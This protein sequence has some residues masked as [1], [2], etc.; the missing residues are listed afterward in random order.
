MPVRCQ[1]CNHHFLLD[2]T[3]VVNGIGCPECGGKTI[4]R[5][6]PSPTHSDGDLRDMVDPATQLD[7]G[8]NPLQEGV[9]AGID[10]GWQPSYRRDESF[11]HVIGAQRVEHPELP[12]AHCGRRGA[13]G[14]YPIRGDAQ[15]RRCGAVFPI[16]ADMGL[17]Q[18]MDVE[19]YRDYP[20][21]FDL[22]KHEIPAN[23]GPTH[24]G[25]TASVLPPPSGIEPQHHFVATPGWAGLHNGNMYWLGYLDASVNGTPV[26]GNMQDLY[27]K[28]GF[29]KHPDFRK[30]VTISVHHPEYEAA[31][32]EIV[33]SGD[34]RSY[35]E[36]MKQFAPTLLETGRK[37]AA[38]QIPAPPG[39]NPPQPQAP[40]V[41]SNHYSRSL[42]MEPYM[43]WWHEAVTRYPAGG[44]EPQELSTEQWANDRRQRHQD[45]QL[46]QGGHRLQ[47]QPGAQGRGIMIGSSLH[48]WPVE[49]TMDDAQGG[50]M[51]G[52]YVKQLGVNPANI[53]L[54][55]GFEIEPDGRVV[56]S[57]VNPAIHTIDP[58]LTPSTEEWGQ[59]FGKTGFAFLAPL[60]AQG[61]RML[62]ARALPSLMG[63]AVRGMG[64]HAQSVPPQPEEYQG[65]RPLNMVAKYANLSFRDMMAM[66]TTAEQRAR[67]L[68]MTGG[69]RQEAFNAGKEYHEIADAIQAQ[70]G[71]N[72]RPDYGIDDDASGIHAHV[73]EALGVG[74]PVETPGSVPDMVEDHDP[75]AV[76]QQEF[77]DGDMSPAFNNP[78]KDDADAGMARSVGEDGVN[79][80][81]E[82][83]HD[84]D[85]VSQAELLLPLIMEYVNS[86]KSA[87]ENPQLKAL[88][89]VLDVEIP[90]YIQHASE[91]D[92]AFHEFM[93]AIKKPQGVEAKVGA[94][95]YQNT[96]MNPNQMAMG[97]QQMQ[98]PQMPMPGTHQNPIGPGGMSVQGKCMN[99][100]GVTNADG[101][102]PQCG[103]SPGANQ[104]GNLEQPGGTAMTQRTPLGIMPSPYA[105]TGANHQ[106]PITPQQKEVFSEYLIQQ[107]RNDEVAAMMV[108]PAIY[109]DEWAQFLNRGTQPPEVDP[110]EQP[111]PQPQMDPS[112]MGQMPVPG[113]SIPPGGGPVASVKTANVSQRAMEIS[114][115]LE[116]QGI[117][118]EQAWQMARRQAQEEFG[119]STDPYNGFQQTMKDFIDRSSRTADSDRRCPECTSA[120]T[121]VMNE[122]G[123]MRCHRCG[124][125]WKA[126]LVK[127]RVSRTW[128]IVAFQDNMTPPS[129]TA[130]TSTPNPIT[131][132]A[133]DLTAPGDREQQADSTLTWQDTGGQPLQV[134]QVYEMHSAV[135]PIPDM[136]KV[137]AVKPDAIVY[138]TVGE[139]NAP[140]DPQDANGPEYS[141]D[142]KINEI[143][144]AGLTFK[145]VDTGD[146]MQPQ[147]QPQDGIGQTVNTEP[148]EQPH[149]SFPTHAKTTSQD[150]CPYC[151]SNDLDDFE[152]GSGR[153]CN[154]CHS[155]IFNN[156]EE[157]PRQ[158]THFESST[159]P[160][161]KCPKCQY[162]HVTSNYTSADTIHY[163]CYRCA[164]SWDI[165][166]RDEGS[167]LSPESREWLQGDDDDDPIG[168]DPRA[169]AMAT[170]GKARN[171]QDIA[172]RDPRNALVKERLNAAKMERVAGA[173]FSPRE[174]RAFIDEDGVAR[175]SNLLDLD[176]THYVS[177]FDNS[178][179]HPDKVNDNYLGLGL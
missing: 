153:Y 105:K 145:P 162:G 38:G 157:N 99:C 95:V 124:H 117:P 71:V 116:A 91:D 168:F 68:M 160:T 11:A 81:L 76:D 175:N 133:A 56:G 46:A 112:Q 103:A 87:L 143:A 163:E 128:R 92:P 22:Q 43:P 88:H 66:L 161:D 158:P 86:D 176:G 149:D 55:S 113:M 108:N 10:G 58:N 110:N 8:G 119:L 178:K 154:S 146:G 80:K 13:V 107:G 35:K 82:F 24:F 64:N 72:P 126:D 28:H 89:D 85:G 165:E 84:G 130:P 111:A 62:L 30:P 169:L 52:E 120:T 134:G 132:P 148:V 100:G 109:A 39:I 4:E 78:N 152:N 49:R 14:I 167:A 98:M 17:E 171:I 73:K 144:E 40:P 65:A 142:I 20:Q 16:G 83:R 1:D 102:C 31:A 50:L 104:M 118:P 21:D 12:C 69:D 6:Q 101:S 121:T 156:P 97:P 90:D 18:R 164:H 139:Y 155:N 179:A 63:M 27:F 147:D 34:L 36:S 25:K 9:W 44:G 173:K 150:R 48:T 141:H 15:C 75:E 159:L 93:E 151:G 29:E 5:D 140:S 125:I 2:G 57:K 42:S 23:L 37:I 70:F 32:R 19:D 60:V 106:G 129:S 177:G 41:M 67:T 26:R 135:S 47:W 94:P 33:E 136:I 53:D 166:D 74:A 7:Q 45:R 137:E 123:Q 96:P 114:R 54:A 59:M 122:D 115:E 174:Q 127:D 51:H 77:N 138:S 61:G 172:H 79:Q 131:A 170:T 3:T